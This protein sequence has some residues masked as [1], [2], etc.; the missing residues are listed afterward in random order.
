MIKNAAKLMRLISHGVYVIS[1]NHEKTDNAFTAAWVMQVSFNPLL[2]CFSINPE[3]YSY[4]ILRQNPVCCISVLDKQQLNLAA[5][6]GSHQ[7]DKMATHQW[8]KTESGA[9]ALAECLAYFDCRVI[10]FTEAGDH[11]VVV[12][13]VIDA[14][15]L[16]AGLP[17]LYVDTENMDNSKE[18]YKK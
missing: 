16:K 6:F 1:V 8:L 7:A 4:Q 5:H 2:I 18:L 9:P 12:A 11:V 3:N 10:S 17:M 13:E 14:K 15:A